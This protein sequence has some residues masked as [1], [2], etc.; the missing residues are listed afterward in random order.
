MKRTVPLAVLAVFST[1]LFTPIAAQAGSEGRRNTAI[2]LGAAAIYSLTKK[3]TT[4]GIVLG[5]GTYYAYR[6]YQDA[7]EDE[8][9][10]KYFR[11]N[12]YKRGYHP[13]KTYHKDRWSR[14]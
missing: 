14:R 4:Q 3:K 1:A 9:R 7:R 13:A 11:S 5:A 8:K 2:L 12:H 10:K 6:K